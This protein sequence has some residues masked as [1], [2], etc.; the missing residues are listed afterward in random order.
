MKH[1]LV[2][3]GHHRDDKMAK[4]QSQDVVIFDQQ[5]YREVL[6]HELEYTQ[7]NIFK[8][9]EQAYNHRPKLS[10]REFGALW[11]MIGGHC[12]VR[13]PTDNTGHNF[14]FTKYN[15]TASKLREVGFDVV[16]KERPNGLKGYVINNLNHYRIKWQMGNFDFYD[17]QDTNVTIQRAINLILGDTTS[18]KKATTKQLSQIHAALLVRE[19]KKL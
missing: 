4:G 13:E 11:V 17:L 16:L 15:G 10:A 5:Y 3:D 19:G 2:K 6:R 7:P 9:M 18:G 12:V 1:P 8:A 14:Y